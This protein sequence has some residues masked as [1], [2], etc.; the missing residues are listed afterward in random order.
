MT[1]IRTARDRARA[2][3]TREIKDEA[4]SQL[5][6]VGPQRL[7]LRSVAREGS[8]SGAARALVGRHC[9]R[10]TG[11]PHLGDKRAER[12]VPP[13]HHKIGDRWT[14]VGQPMLNKTRDSPRPATAGVKDQPAFTLSQPMFNRVEIQAHPLQEIS[15]LDRRLLDEGLTI[16]H[17]RLSVCAASGTNRDGASLR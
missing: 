9:R 13:R 6:A 12:K 7:S 4:R 3:L 15:I 5:A 8:L 1:A 2:E 11:Q 17:S 10:Q 16:G 14:V